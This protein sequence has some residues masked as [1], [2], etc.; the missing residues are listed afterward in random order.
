MLE[1]HVKCRDDDHVDRKVLEMQLSEKI[2]R[3]RQKSRYFG[4]GVGG[5]A[6]GRTERRLSVCSKC[7][8]N[9]LWRLVM[10]KP[11]E[12]DAQNVKPELTLESRVALAD[13]RYFGHDLLCM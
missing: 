2:K 12:E 4:R 13:L 3:G 11:K 9:M 8:E 7:M 10:G 1:N 5:H 6:E